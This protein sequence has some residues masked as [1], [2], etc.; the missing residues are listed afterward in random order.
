VF[1]AD[2]LT[3]YDAII[4]LVQKQNDETGWQLAYILKDMIT[5][6]KFVWQATPQQLCDAL[7][8]ATRKATI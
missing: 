1:N 7:L 6:D 2:Y 3:S 8:V 4:P 5:E